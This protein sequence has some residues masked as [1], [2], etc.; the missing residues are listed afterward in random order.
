MPNKMVYSYLITHIVK[1]INICLHTVKGYQLFL[2]NTNN[3]HSYMV[4]IGLVGLGF[5]AY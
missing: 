2:S 3:L 4:S 5:L 1:I